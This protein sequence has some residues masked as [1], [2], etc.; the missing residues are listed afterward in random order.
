MPAK[1][2]RFAAV[3][4]ELDADRQARNGCK[5]CAFIAAEA[6]VDQE[7]VRSM[8]ADPLKS[9]SHIVRVLAAGGF[10]IGESSV[11]RHRRDNHAG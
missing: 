8:L 5:V 9:G 11:K 4:A 6:P 2:S 10:K 1:T 3:D 7:Y